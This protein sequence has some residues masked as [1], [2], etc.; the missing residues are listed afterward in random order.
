MKKTINRRGFIALGSTFALN[1]RGCWDLTLSVE[2]EWW[3]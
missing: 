2:L 3:S 1:R